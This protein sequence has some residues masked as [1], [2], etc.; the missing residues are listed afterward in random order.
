VLLLD[1]LWT[2]GKPTEGTSEDIY[3]SEKILIQ[4][5]WDHYTSYY[6]VTHSSSFG[7]KAAGDG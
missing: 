7:P 1:E 6:T 4:Q 3:M 2:A 5:H